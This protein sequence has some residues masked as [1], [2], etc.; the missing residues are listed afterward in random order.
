MRSFQFSVASMVFEPADRLSHDPVPV[1]EAHHSSFLEVCH[2]LLV[3]PFAKLPFD[4]QHPP[5][6]V[7]VNKL[8]HVRRRLIYEVTSRRHI[9]C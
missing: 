3:G 7:H 5:T 2:F 1:H 9:I 8:C 4:H 6:A